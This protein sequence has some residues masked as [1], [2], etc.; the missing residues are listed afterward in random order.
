[1]PI[2]FA[3]GIWDRYITDAFLR[4]KHEYG[5]PVVQGGSFVTGDHNDLGPFTVSRS[6]NVDDLPGSVKS[7]LVSAHN[8]NANKNNG[9]QL[10][11][12]QDAV[13]RVW[14]PP[15]RR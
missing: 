15:H 12:K 11:H 14:T 6:L 2:E 10:L 4:H 7:S 8:Q 5:N 1:M 13:M 9:F 3:I